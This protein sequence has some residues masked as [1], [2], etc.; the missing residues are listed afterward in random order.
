MSKRRF[1]RTLKYKGRLS[2]HTNIRDFRNRNLHSQPQAQTENVILLPLT[3]GMVLD[4]Q[5]RRQALKNLMVP[6]TPS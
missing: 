4:G 5:Y 2:T 6:D 1:A 3:F